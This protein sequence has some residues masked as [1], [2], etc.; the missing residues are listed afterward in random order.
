LSWCER[1][2]QH[3]GIQPYVAAVSAAF[4]AGHCSV[5]FGHGWQVLSTNDFKA[6]FPLDLASRM[7]FLWYPY[8]N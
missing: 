1:L 8:P 2:L 6:Y 4:I 7:Y 3:D 5:S